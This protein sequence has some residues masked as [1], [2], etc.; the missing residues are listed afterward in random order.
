MTTEL[1]E[2]KS[3]TREVMRRY[4]YIEKA[5]DAN[6]FGIV[7]ATLGVGMI[8]REDKTEKKATN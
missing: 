2:E 5:K 8:E 3:V 4:H 6:V 7:V 1:K